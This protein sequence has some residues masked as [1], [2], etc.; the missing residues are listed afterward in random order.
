MG[1]L[2]A[3]WAAQ[4]QYDRTGVYNDIQPGFVEDQVY[5]FDVA[6]DSE[7][8]EVIATIPPV[9]PI[10]NPTPSPVVGLGTPGRFDDWQYTVTGITTTSTLNGNYSTAT[11]RGVFLVVLATVQNLGLESDYISGFDFVAQ[12]S[13]TRQYD[14]AGLNAQW[15]AEDQFGRT[16]V[17]HDIQL[18]I[19]CTYS[20]SYQVRAGYTSFLR[21]LEMLLI[22][23]ND[24][25]NVAAS[26]VCF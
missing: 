4:D 26:P 10:P 5:V 21:I 13:S 22:L 24:V 15:A 17:Y 3:Q 11:A 16:G 20:T 8:L 18:K 14:M 19:K 9:T 23:D 25:E 12:D 2:V 6:L 7:G 1:D